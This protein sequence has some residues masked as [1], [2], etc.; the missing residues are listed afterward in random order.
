MFNNAEKLMTK[1]ESLSIQDHNRWFCNFD[2][3]CNSLTALA[4]ETTQSDRVNG[5]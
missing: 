5:E 2:L 4:R 1:Q 3:V